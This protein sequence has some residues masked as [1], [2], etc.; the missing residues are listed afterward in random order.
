MRIM[1]FVLGI[2][3]AHIFVPTQA[4]AFTNIARVDTGAA[5]TLFTASRPGPES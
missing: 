1:L 4:T 3:I 5:S 2:A